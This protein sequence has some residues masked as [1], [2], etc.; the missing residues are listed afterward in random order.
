MEDGCQ[1]NSCLSVSSTSAK[2]SV[3]RRCTFNTC[4]VVKSF[5]HC[6]T[7]CAICMYAL[8]NP[9]CFASSAQHLR[10][11]VTSQPLFKRSH[12]HCFAQV[13]SISRSVDV[14]LIDRSISHSRYR[15]QLVH[16]P[17]G[18]YGQY[19]NRPSI[20]LRQNTGD[21]DGRCR[22]TYGRLRSISTLTV[23]PP[24]GKYGRYRWSIRSIVEKD[25]SIWTVNVDSHQ[26]KM[27]DGRNRPSKRTQTQKIKSRLTLTWP[28][29]FHNTQIRMIDSDSHF[30]SPGPTSSAL[31]KTTHKK[32]RNTQ[33][34]RPRWTHSQECLKE[35][36]MVP[37]ID[38][39]SDHLCRNRLQWF[40]TQTVRCAYSWPWAF[41]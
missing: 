23:D 35:E 24:T 10:P 11:A 12:K 39:T 14:F 26:K 16:P 8:P 15:H 3:P 38:G 34:Q 1:P 40:R 2:R 7:L 41:S 30:C 31:H 20:H 19:Q 21:P 37:E 32:E 9:G 6:V 17:T 5:K 13:S 27:I 33:R 36:L 29:T 22:F 4:S 28:P 18:K 25:Q